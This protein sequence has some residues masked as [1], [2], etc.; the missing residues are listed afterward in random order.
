MSGGVIINESGNPVVM[1][2][3]NDGLLESIGLRTYGAGQHYATEYEA[4]KGAELAQTAARMSRQEILDFEWSKQGYY[5]QL[6]AN[7]YENRGFYNSMRIWSD[8]DK[9]KIADAGLIP[10][11][12][13]ALKRFIDT[14]LGEI[15]AS[16][17]E[18]RAL[19]M[20]IMS[21]DKAEFMNHL[22]RSV[23]QQNDWDR[24]Q[25]QVIKDALIAGVGVSS[26]MLDPLHPTGRIRIERNKPEEFMIDLE[27]AKNGSF[28]GSQYVWRGYYV[29]RDQMMWE[30]PAQAETI[31]KLNTGAF[32]SASYHLN[33]FL[34]PQVMRTATGKN[35]HTY[36]PLSFGRNATRFVFKRE[37]YRR[38]EILRWV[39]TDI[40][41]GT[42][43]KVETQEQAV[44]IYMQL[45]EYYMN[46]AIAFGF[47]M[48]DV[49][50]TEPV[51]AYVPAIDQEIWGNEQLLAIFTTTDEYIPY[52]FC[53]PEFQDGEITSFFQHGK[54]MVRL[55]NRALMMLDW[56][57]LNVTGKTVVNKRYMPENMTEDQIRKQVKSATEPIIVDSSDPNA[58]DNIFRHFSPPSMGTV[59]SQ[60]FAVAS[61]EGQMTFGGL[62][63]I[64]I[65]ENAGE[66]GRA[67]LARQRASSTAVIPVR[68]ELKYY[69][70]E[71][72][73]K[74]AYLA[75][76]LDPATQLM[77]V[78]DDGRPQYRSVISDGMQTISELRFKIDI[79]E[80]QKS[81][82]ERE[83][84]ITRLMSILQ[85]APQT[86]P[87]ILPLYLRYED[88]DIS[89]KREIENYL[90]EA[91]Q[92][93]RQMQ[94]EESNRQNA[95]VESR[96]R[97]DQEDMLIKR[98]VA[99][100]EVKG[101]PSI[102]LTGKIGEMPP[103]AAAD[104]YEKA[105]IDASPALINKDADDMLKYDEKREKIRAKYAPKKQHP[106][107]GRMRRKQW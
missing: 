66:S 107:K 10:Y 79:N 38:R 9:Q 30:F 94:I 13:P 45:H 17:T 20:D 23:A 97:R 59:F 37:F 47:Q 64:G 5:K 83:A 15:A 90:R 25:L 70:R 44:Y 3:E 57:G 73:E 7:I 80:V 104:I 50:A 55:K 92:F 39:V 2:G 18:W 27:T 54:D 76:Y 61:D 58:M 11:A 81:P 49:V 86:A 62:N 28:H 43:Y 32:V 56:I 72:G 35:N 91:E 1:S 6:H 31:K 19:G 24:V 96:I 68:E 77:Y 75:Q 99:E 29:P 22:L 69:Q 103:R 63:T 16:R 88:V 53:T 93:D 101:I 12:T 34:S 60:L 21:E 42:T 87:A 71:V 46:N 100:H 51:Q 40:I 85:Q 26:T 52:T 4:L 41:R 8:E 65:T 95:V 106:P 98:M 74:V 67:V 14:L 36:N 105:G 89:V 33:T 82:S 78:N 48:P 102:T 84:Q